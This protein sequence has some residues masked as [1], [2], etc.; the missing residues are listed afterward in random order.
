[1]YV[2]SYI[3]RSNIA[4]AI[5]AMRSEFGLS[6]S[7]IGFATGRFFGDTPSRRFQPDT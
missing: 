7:A 4:M 1:M 3:D 6:V 5:P 2:L